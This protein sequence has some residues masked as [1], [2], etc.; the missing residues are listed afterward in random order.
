MDLTTLARKPEHADTLKAE[1]AATLWT[2]GNLAYKLD[3]SQLQIR[4]AREAAWKPIAP[5]TPTELAALPIEE[6]TKRANV[7]IVFFELCARGWGKTFEE[8]VWLLEVGLTTKGGRMLFA[9]PLRDDAIVT[10]K[11]ILDL[12]ILTDAPDDVK[13]VWRAGDA[14]YFFPSTEAVLRFRGVNNESRE[15][16]RGPG[17]HAVVLDECGTMDNL[18]SVLG[19]V[20]PIA[21]RLGGKVLLSTTPAETPG[22]ESK[23][24]YDECFARG[25]SACFTLLDNARLTW[26]GKAAALMEGVGAE[27]PADV[28]AILSGAMLPRKTKTRRERWCLWVAES[29]KMVH[30]AW[31]D[32]EKEL[33]APA[34]RPR[35]AFFHAFEALDVGFIDRT[36]WL[37][38]YVDFDE[39]Q[40][41]IED[42]FL[43]SRASTQD[44]ADAIE[45]HERGLWGPTRVTGG[46]KQPVKRVSDVDHRLIQDLRSQHSLEFRAIEKKNFDSDINLVNVLISSKQLLVSE[47]CVHLRKQLREGVFAKSGRDM[48]RDALG[49]HYDLLAALRYGC[50]I[51]NL[52]LDP[53][54]PGF[55]HKP[56]N[57]EEFLDVPPEKKASLLPDS[58][59]GRRIEAKAV[60]PFGVS[61]FRRR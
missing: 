58:P 13:P 20:E 19:I 61:P 14:E 46:Q 16:L 57:A 7:S 4:A 44:I 1:I 8:L 27:D 12:F 11:D 54:P 25:V 55:K 23:E 2:R 24:I 36:G 21:S 28:P 34:K 40:I 56:R 3:P 52:R 53:F 35:P 33:T 38:G 39:A 51:A 9:S 60:R 22:H 17:Y 42:E 10:A 41:V 31:P 15:R 32:L 5:L 43:L 59:L 37:A 48:A 29:D 45:A 47:K 6:R 50:R 26:D 30:P 18:K 49:G